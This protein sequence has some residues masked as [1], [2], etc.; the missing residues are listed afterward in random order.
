MVPAPT[1][2][3]PAG[4]EGQGQPGSRAGGSTTQRFWWRITGWHLIMNNT[5]HYIRP[6]CRECVRIESRL[7]HVILETFRIVPTTALFCP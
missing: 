6:C 7:H 3:A 4:P 1:N 5:Q 2:L